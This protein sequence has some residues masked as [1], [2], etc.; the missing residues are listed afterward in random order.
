MCVKTFRKSISHEVVEIAC[1][2]F[3][4]SDLRKLKRNDAGNEAVNAV[5]LARYNSFEEGDTPPKKNS[6]H[7]IRTSWI[8]KKYVLKTWHQ[9]LCPESV[10]I[11]APDPPATSMVHS[12][13]QEPVDNESAPIPMSDK[14]LLGT[15]ERLSSKDDFNSQSQ[16]LKNFKRVPSNRPSI[17]TPNESDQKS[18]KRVTFSKSFPE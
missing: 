9:T 5:Y 11:D 7:L 15:K 1:H 2:N 14:I 18:C 8:M 3:S 13:Y 17:L 10:V 6:N 4:T 16:A 12:L